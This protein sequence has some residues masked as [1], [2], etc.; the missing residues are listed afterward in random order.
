[1]P[2]RVTSL[3]YLRWGSDGGDD[4]DCSL[5][6][7]DDVWTCRRLP[8]KMAVF[9]VVAPCSL[10]EIYIAIIALVMKAARTSETLVNFYQTT[11]CYN[12]EDSQ[13]SS[14]SPSW[15]PQILLGYQRF[16]GTCCLHL[17]TLLRE[18]GG[19]AFLR[20]VGNHLQDCTASQPRRPRYLTA[21]NHCIASNTMRVLFRKLQ[22]IENY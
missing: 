12:P 9:W 8:T 19:D 7:C 21:L 22:W 6:G 14:Y 4:I 3:H 17:Q 11:R 1:M 18:Y 10:V 13:P 2:K 15:E 16:G 5:L 20:N